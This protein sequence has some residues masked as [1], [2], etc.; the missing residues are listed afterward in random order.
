MRW[1][2]IRGPTCAADFFT[3]GDRYDDANSHSRVEWY[4]SIRF[5]REV[6]AFSRHL[7]GARDAGC[8]LAALT[9]GC[10][11]GK[12]VQSRP[13]ILCAKTGW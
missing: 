12:V 2:E 8:D 9:R 13:S 6:E 3:K 1:L 10:L 5:Q 4:L 7:R 11:I